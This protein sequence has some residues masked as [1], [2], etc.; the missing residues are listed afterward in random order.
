M[1]A[2]QAPAHAVPPPISYLSNILQAPHL[3]EYIYLQA[4]I[5]FSL[6]NIVSPVRPA[7]L[8]LIQVDGAAPLATVGASVDH[9]L[10]DTLYLYIVTALL[11]NK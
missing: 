3:N 6:S 1:I 7:R 5:A 8:A 2:A 11:P 10:P 9:V 4:N